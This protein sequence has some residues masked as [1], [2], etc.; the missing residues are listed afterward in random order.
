S[1]Y[2]VTVT[3]DNGCSLTEIV[4]VSEP[5][6]VSLSLSPNINT[7]ICPGSTILLTATASGGNGIYNYQWSDGNS[8]S[9]NSVSPSSPTVYTVSVTDQNGCTTTPESVTIDHYPLLTL[10]VLNPPEICE[11][12][13]ALISASVSGGFGVYSF[14]WST[15]QTGSTIT[16][17]PQYST[18]YPVTVTDG[19]GTSINGVG[20]VTVNPI[21]VT[22]FVV[23][24]TEACK[25]IFASFS[26]NTPGSGNSYLWDF[27]DNTISSQINPV[28]YYSIPGT[29]SVSLISTSPI[30][31]VSSLTIPNAVTVY[32]EPV[33]G[34]TYT[35]QTEKV[36]IDTEINFIDLSSGASSWLWNFG[37]NTASSTDQNP[38]HIY[39]EEGYFTI[40]QIVLNNFGCRDT[41]IQ[42]IQVEELFNIYLPNA[43][44]PDD[45]GFNEI[46]SAQGIGIHGF[47]MFIFNRWGDQIYYT[48]DLNKGWNG[49]DEKSGT[50]HPIGVYVYV[51]KAKD[52]KGKTKEII[53]QVT[54]VR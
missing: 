47:E 28:H 38:I 21:P 36:L 9:T 30:G 1:N 24:P 10:N 37:D 54:L 19:C 26:N 20:I 6:A 50:Q 33:A 44:T 39:R 35:P 31:C 53:G 52:K 27:G 3:D 42:R 43:F 15:G 8:G 49:I 23:G 40:E 22:D 13:S 48:T 5:T 41:A 29:Y 25:E 18:N 34:F 45:D 14:N 17:T 51:V 16:V 46:F 4:T 7:L 2:A 12:E 11:G 32:P